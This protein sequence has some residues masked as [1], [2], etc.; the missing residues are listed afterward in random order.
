[1]KIVGKSKIKEEILKNM[2]LRYAIANRR[3]DITLD[4]VV[5]KQYNQQSRTS[6]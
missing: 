3:T 5:R 4:F 2:I 6:Q 1:M